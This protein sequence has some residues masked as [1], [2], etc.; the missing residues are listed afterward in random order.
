[1]NKASY[2]EGLAYLIKVEP[3][4][5]KFNLSEDISFFIRPEGFKGICAL[6]I[7][8]QISVQ[9]ANS[10]KTRVF[11]LMRE[12]NSNYFL[13][14]DENQLREAG[15]S[16]PKISYLRGVATQESNGALDFKKIQLLDDLSARRE[17]CKIR[18]IG[19]WTADCYLM[20]ALGRTDIWPVGDIGLQA[21]VQKLKNLKE[22]PNVEDMTSIAREWRPFRSVA[23]NLLWADYD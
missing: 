13:E 7:E 17:L 2:Q 10:I 3:A 15:L 21:S 4:F 5:K 12:V 1:M 11:G 6:V 23:A 14:L 18:G 8:Q 20:A 9:A 16:R 19:E 22:R